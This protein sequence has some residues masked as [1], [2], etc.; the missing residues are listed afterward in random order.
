MRTLALT[1]AAA[2][3]ALMAASNGA[4]AWT[5]EQPAQSGGTAI[6]LSDPDKFQA[7]QDKVNGTSQS[8]SGFFITGGVNGG[9]SD[10]L[11]PVNPYG[12]QPL[13]RGSAFSYSPQPGF[14]R[15]AAVAGSA[16]TPA[17][18]PFRATVHSTSLPHPIYSIDVKDISF[19][20]AMP[21]P[22]GWV[23]R[24]GLISRY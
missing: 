17:P 10:G 16:V 3:V 4:W 2:I 8:Q 15:G 23:A 5:T 19:D 6:D 21:R 14:R 12:L 13:G 18:W 11:S 9:S 22:W 20:V 1:R 24:S 7:L